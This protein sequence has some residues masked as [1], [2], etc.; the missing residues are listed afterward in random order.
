MSGKFVPAEETVREQLDW[1]SLAWCSR[2]ATTGAEAMVVIEVTL[3]P[4]GGHA[5]HKHPQQEEVI[6]VISGEVEQ[7]LDQEKRVLSAGDSVF[8]PAEVVHATFN[9][10][11]TDAKLLAILS[12]SIGE[13]N[14]YEVLEV[15]DEEPWK[16][17]D[18]G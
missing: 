7:W 5:F 4:G 18:R 16:G 6:Y 12:P 9:T 11:G 10:S 3:A 13:E 17:L 14:G 2:P 15:A 1:G 8:V